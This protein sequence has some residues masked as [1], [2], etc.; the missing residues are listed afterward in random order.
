MSNLLLLIYS[1]IKKNRNVY[2]ITIDYNKA[3]DKVD[4]TFL[5][6]KLSN[7][8]LQFFWNIISLL[9]PNRKQV[10]QI[11]NSQSEALPVTSGIPQKSILS[12]G[13]ACTEKIDRLNKK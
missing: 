4:H 11:Y 9:I 3:F 12:I 8:I 2:I 1:N 6:N 5:I 10:V 13:L 7:Y